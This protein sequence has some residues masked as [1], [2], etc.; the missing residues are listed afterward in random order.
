MCHEMMGRD[1]WDS[2]KRMKHEKIVV[3]TH[4]ARRLTT[5]GELKKPVVLRIPADSDH[6]ANV[7]Q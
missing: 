2:L 1:Y 4:D 7:H 5:H 6:D 3:T